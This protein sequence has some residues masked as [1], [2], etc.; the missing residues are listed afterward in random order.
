MHCGPK[1]HAVAA[2]FNW[3]D[4]RGT[5][6]A[7][8][9]SGFGLSAFSFATIASFAFGD[10]ISS[11]LLMLAVGTLCLN[12]ASF[13]FMRLIPTPHS[14]SALP[15]IEEARPG[16]TRADSSPMLPTKSRTPDNYSPT[17]TGKSLHSRS[18][19][20]FIGG[21][22]A[23]TTTTAKSG[24]D[25]DETSSLML[26]PSTCSDG[27][28]DHELSKDAHNSPPHVEITGL[29]LLPTAEFWQL[30]SMLGLLSGV[31]LM[32]IK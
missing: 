13:F 16:L 28:A 6:T 23:E 20:P 17:K 15:S 26:P 29:K 25:E 4:H 7:L 9:L 18:L 30:F 19:Q 8:P 1:T 2:T 11:F 10:D 31:G 14:Y 12:V 3:P 21:S 5:A 32:T 22:A 24:D 27:F